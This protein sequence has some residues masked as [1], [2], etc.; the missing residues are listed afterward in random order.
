MAGTHE[1]SRGMSYG[2]KAS[3]EQVSAGIDLSGRHAI[4]TGAN[5]GIGFETARV[6][7]LRGS[8]VTMACRNLEKADTA[9]TRILEGV[10]EG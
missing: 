8:S 2:K 6:L 1:N 7:A 4:V 9:R 5:T 3:A 10:A